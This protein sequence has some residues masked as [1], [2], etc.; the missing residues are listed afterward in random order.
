MQTPA[1]VS[2]IEK[3]GL[4]WPV[5]DDDFGVSFFAEVGV[6]VWCALVPNRAYGQED[7]VASA[8]SNPPHI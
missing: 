3:W 6:I 2:D 4:R 8:S 5:S 1:A 7:G